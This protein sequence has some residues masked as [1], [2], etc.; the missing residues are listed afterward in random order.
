M[1]TAVSVAQP[2]REQ[3]DHVINKQ[4]ADIQNGLLSILH[5]TPRKLSNSH[6]CASY[7]PLR[8]IH[9]EMEQ[10][11]AAPERRI[12]ENFYQQRTLLDYQNDSGGWNVTLEKSATKKQNPFF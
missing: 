12:L 4:A 7:F 9:I 3:T 2:N 8:H 6:L 1:I 5:Y 10:R 11:S